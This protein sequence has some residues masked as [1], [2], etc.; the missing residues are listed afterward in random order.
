VTLT[1]AAALGAGTVLA[2]PRTATPAAAADNAENTGTIAAATMGANTML[3]AYS[4]TCITASDGAA[5]FSV[6]APNGAYLGQATEDVA[7]ADSHLGFTITDDTTEFSAGESFT[8]TV[9]E[10]GARAQFDDTATDGKQIPSGIL[11]AAAD[12]S[13]GDVAA[14][15]IARDAE[16][17]S[18]LLIWPST[19]DATDK[20][21]A[22]NDLAAIGI[23]VRAGT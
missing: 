10:T 23:I 1:G 7:Y 3:G 12:P 19:A 13:D 5:V 4:I 18:N 14:V 22:I 17:A 2:K 20:L 9:A 15:E 6:Y 8:V 21:I 16:V 11:L